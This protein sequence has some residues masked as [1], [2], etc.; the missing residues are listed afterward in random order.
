MFYQF[1]CS[2][3]VQSVSPG[4]RRAEKNVREQIQKCAAGGRAGCH[5]PVCPEPAATG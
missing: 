3:G 5:L 4:E 1:Y 2:L